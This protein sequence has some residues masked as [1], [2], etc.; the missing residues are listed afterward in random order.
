MEKKDQVHNLIILDESGSMMSIKNFIISGFNELVQ[1]IK[2]IE[3]EYPDQEHFISFITF[4][5]LGSNH[6][7]ILHFIDPVSK[8]REINDGAYQPNGSTPLY[9]AIGFAVNKLDQVVSK[10]PACNV[11]VTIMTDGE[12]N[13]SREFSGPAINAL[14]KEKK[15]K[16]WTFTYIGADHDIESAAGRIAVNNTMTFTK[17]VKGVEEMFRKERASRAAYSKRIHDKEKGDFD[18]Y[19]KE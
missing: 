5:G 13:A 19:D 9:D 7:K 17:S 3:Q 2:G 16:G 1:T 14:I 10:L 6:N 8:L 15:E 11:L 12:E 4:N 18:F